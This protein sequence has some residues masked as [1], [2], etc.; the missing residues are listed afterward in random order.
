VLRRWLFWANLNALHVV[1]LS[2]T[3][4]DAPQHL[5]RVASLWPANVQEFRPAVGLA[6]DGE[7]ECEGAEYHLALKGDP[8]AGSALL[9]TSIQAGML[10]A[11]LLTPRTQS[12]SSD[13]TRVRSDVFF[14]KKV[15]AF[16]DNLDSV[17]RWFNDMSD[18][19]A[20]PTLAALRRKTGLALPPSQI[21]RREQGG[22]IW[23][24]PE[25]IGHDLTRSLVVS[26]CSSQDPGANAGSDL[27]IATSSLEV[28]FDDPDV[29]AMLHHKRP[30]SIASFIQRKGRAGRTRGSRPWTVTV[31]SDYG[32]DRWAFQSAEKLFLPEVTA[33]LLP[34]A[35]P[36][37]LRVQ[38]AFFLLDWI[39]QRIHG[40][41]GVYRVLSGPLND[42][43]NRQVQL[44]VADLLRRILD[45]GSPWK[46]FQRDFSRF[47]ERFSGGTRENIK[48]TIDDVLWHEP[49]PI[50][51]EVIPSLLRK[52]ECNWERA[53]PS[54]HGAREDAGAKRP[55][56]QFI[57]AST[58][59]ELEAGEAVL[60]LEAFGPQ[61]RQSEMVPVNKL[62][63]ETCPGRVSK[64]FATAL[65]ERGYWHPWSSK[66]DAGH[67]SARVSE[68]YSQSTQIDFVNGVFVYQPEQAAVVHRPLSVADSS[69]GSWDWQVIGRSQ[70]PSEP[71]PVY[72]EKPW[73]DVFS[74]A[75]VYLHS[76]SAWLDILRFTS[77]ARFEKRELRQSVMGTVALESPTDE[78]GTQRQA[79]G[80]RV[81]ADGFRCRPRNN[82]V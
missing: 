81:R 53:Y 80:Y 63:F 13:E 47:L 49:R 24:L 66:L 72:S 65:N 30:R 26:R 4:Q 77:S 54:A 51:T 33:L 50:I 39:G 55:I 35:N 12:T 19:E 38:A 21:L 11:R 82:V 59:D 57:P 17:N 31:L 22:Q 73:T 2:A 64:R 76:N 44:R 20:S 52:L 3:L 1:G 62:L 79:L 61:V 48:A 34:I 16:T 8:A 68:L 60:D 67:N 28:G 5:A 75:E 56:P 43:E 25:E 29:G 7:M 70:G 69:S 15:F 6:P 23:E 74:C 45:G 37:V 14:R 27:I 9:S 32:A 78:G 46:D 10:L 18:A 58:Y 42:Y 40:K 41:D 71:L 36:F